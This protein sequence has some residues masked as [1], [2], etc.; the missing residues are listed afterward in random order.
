MLQL[1]PAHAVW[2]ILL[3]WGWVLTSILDIAGVHDDIRFL[4]VINLLALAGS[5]CGLF[6]TVS[7]PSAGA[8]S[9]K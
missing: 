4:E 3:N 5:D 6:G 9:T 2:I 7:G 1:V 8:I